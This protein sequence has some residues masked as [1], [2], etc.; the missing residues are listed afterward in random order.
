VASGGLD[1]GHGS[2]ASASG[3]G[4]ARERASL[5]EMRQGRE[6]GCARCSKGSWGAWADDVAGFSAHVCAGPRRFAGKADL[7]GN[8][9]AHP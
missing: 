1:G 5:C 3:E 2:P 7:T 6:S 9:T 8:P 4:R